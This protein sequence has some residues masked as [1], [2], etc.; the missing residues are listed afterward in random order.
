[1]RV[2]TAEVA[3][4]ATADDPR[5]DRIRDLAP[6]L[7]A[8]VTVRTD[9]SACL[10]SG[11]LTTGEAAALRQLGA[12]GHIDLLIRP[13]IP[14]SARRLVMLDVDSTMIRN[15]V[16][17]LLAEEAGC[18]DRVADIT[19][20]AMAGELDFTGSLTERVALLA[21]LDAGAIDRARERMELTCGADRLVD[22][23]HAAGHV[24]AVVS[25]GFTPF[26]EH[27]RDLLGLD[28]A[29]ANTLEVIDGQLTGRVLGEIVDAEVKTR[30][31]IEVAASY[32]ILLEHTV[33]IGDGANDLGMI[34]AAGIGIAFCAK[35]VV[36]AGADAS[37]SVPRLDAVLALLGVGA[38]GR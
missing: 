16:I 1:A 38:P 15:E 21:G 37:I 28:H 30:T 4:L 35:P 20:R 12:E 5:L 22:E 19:S 13:D 11:P 23:L 7:G 14:T 3:V 10:L 17:E 2:N 34:T 33:A 25:G 6:H 18:G 36:R 8:P 26:T 32:D 29:R 24:V 31:L 9:P 27:L